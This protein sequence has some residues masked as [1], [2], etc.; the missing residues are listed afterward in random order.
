MLLSILVNVVEIDGC[1]MFA[2]E[3]VVREVIDATDVTMV[4]AFVFV[5]KVVVLRVTLA[6]YVLHVVVVRCIIFEVSV[7]KVCGVDVSVCRTNVWNGRVKDIVVC[8]TAEVIVL[9]IVDRLVLE[10]RVIV[11]SALSC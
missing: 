11:G 1:V 7:V 5:V 4:V 10:V 2:S 6:T 8:E 9:K 3:G